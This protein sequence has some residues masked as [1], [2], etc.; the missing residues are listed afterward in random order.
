MTGAPIYLVSACSSG[1]EFVA[2]FRRYADKNGLFIPI[3]EPLPPGRRNR[4]AVTLR[5]GG[6]MIEGEAE[7]VSSARAPSLVHGRVGMTLRFVTPDE[8]SRTTLAE[9]EK[10]RLAMKPPPPSVPPRPSEIPAEPR[11]VPPPI[12]GRID[13]VN[14]LAECVAIGDTSVLGPPLPAAPPKAAPRSAPPTTPPAVRST[15]GALPPPA[16]LGVAPVPRRTP[17]TVPPVIA[18][19]DGETRSP[20]PD[21]IPAP[22]PTPRATPQREQMRAA[23]AAARSRLTGRTRTVSGTP[24]APPLSPPAAVPIAT[25]AA[26]IDR[27]PTSE[28]MIAAVPPAPPPGLGREMAGGVTMNAVPLPAVTSPSSPTEIGGALVVPIEDEISGRTQIHAGAPKPVTQIPSGA[29]AGAAPPRAHAEPPPRSAA[30]APAVT[31]IG[32][33]MTPRS[34]AQL[35]PDIEIA[36]PTDI[37]MPPELPNASSTGLIAVPD[38]SAPLVP[39]TDARTAADTDDDSGRRRQTRLG[40]VVAPDG[41]MVLPAMPSGPVAQPDAEALAA[42]EPTGDQPV[43]GDSTIDE[44]TP[45]TPWTGGAPGEPTPAPTEP[46]A[47]PP[48]RTPPAGLPSGDWTIALDP[49]APD[50]WSAPFPT[51]P[52]AAAAAAKL[53]DAAE[54]PSPEKL[55]DAEPKVQ[56]DPTL[57]EPAQ[58]LGS[59]TGLG[60][61][62]GTGLA[63]SDTVLYAA[64]ATN[65]TAPELAALAMPMQ[66]MSML[67]QQIPQQ[68]PVMAMP[69]TAYPPHGHGAPIGHGGPVAAYPPDAVYPPMLMAP[70]VLLPGQFADAQYAGELARMERARRRLIILLASAV[71]VVLLGIIALLVFGS[72]RDASTPAAAATPIAPSPPSPAT[73]STAPPAPATP[74]AAAPVAPAPTPADGSGHAAAAAAPAECYADVRSQPPGA[75]IVIDENRIIGTTPTRVALPCGAPIDLVLKKPRLTPVI[76]TVTPTPEGAVVQVA[77]GKQ[78][79]LVKVST[80]PPGA[81]IT[82]GGKSLGVTPTV[83][84]LPAFEASE[85]SLT[86]DGYEPDTE[87]V[88]PKTN[89]AAVHSVLRKLDRKRPR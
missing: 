82:V 48:R 56:I 57:I 58:S 44:P 25:P 71:V 43:L 89:G 76:R 78:S 37:S 63:L 61:A 55:P 9:L 12:Q 52:A 3:A 41:M 36:E 45:S 15:P 38:S 33:P 40:V 10:A 7:I 20:I 85:L 67:P 51:V 4:F 84:K 5:D 21:P 18:R 68:M 46:S 53:A 39:L 49:D 29:I 62:T 2:A 64:S 81:T 34:P 6:V 66:Q 59:M 32:V 70:A 35:G 88:A 16:E 23:E 72:P 24:P 1:D 14:A 86:K 50:G 47:Q 74:P 79:F 30:L 80:V 75:D 11:P 60:S 54:A 26:G 87:T 42:D 17:P 28:T 8:P 69:P 19:T 13:A 77:L 27:G 22:I 31:V 83:I 73:P 65:E